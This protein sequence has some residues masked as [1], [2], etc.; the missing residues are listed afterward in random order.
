[1]NEIMPGNSKFAHFGYIMIS[2]KP[3][4]FNLSKHLKRHND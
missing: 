2:Y 3:T 4:L 1:M